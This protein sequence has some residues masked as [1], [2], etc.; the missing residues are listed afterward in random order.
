MGEY[1][2]QDLKLICDNVVRLAS[3]DGR[4]VAM[5][6][7]VAGTSTSSTRV[8]KFEAIV[9]R[10]VSICCPVHTAL[11]DGVYLVSMLLV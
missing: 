10:K 7:V 3:V 1:A 6:L 11:V 9:T 2:R 5:R 4:Y 8:I